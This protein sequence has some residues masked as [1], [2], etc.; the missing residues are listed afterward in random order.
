MHIYTYIFSMQNC[1]VCGYSSEFGRIN[2]KT[3]AWTY[4][5]SLMVY[6]C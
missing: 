3:Q 5:S 2:S 4:G 6:A 1:Y